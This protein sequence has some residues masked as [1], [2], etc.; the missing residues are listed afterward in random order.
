MNFFLRLHLCG[1]HPDR[2]LGYSVTPDSSCLPCQ[3]TT[4]FPKALTDL[5]SITTDHFCLC[6]YFLSM[7]PH[8]MH[9]FVS[10]L[11]LS[12][13]L[14]PFID[15]AGVSVPQLVSSPLRDVWVVSSAGLLRAK[16]PRCFS[17]VWSG[18]AG[19]GGGRD[20]KGVWRNSGWESWV[21]SLS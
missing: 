13:M 19:R 20:D 14:S 11:S 9:S 7:G 21:C 8:N 17:T 15:S 2:C 6:L 16:L 3:V 5:I 18:R 4:S 12:T 10:G 1:H